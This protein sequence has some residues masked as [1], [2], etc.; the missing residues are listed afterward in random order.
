MS[1]WSKSLYLLIAIAVVIGIADYYNGSLGSWYSQNWAYVTLFIGLCFPVWFGAW[2]FLEVIIP[3]DEK[4]AKEKELRKSIFQKK[5]INERG[6]ELDALTDEEKEY[7][8]QEWVNEEEKAELRRKYLGESTDTQTAYS[9]TK[10]EDR[11]YPLSQREKEAIIN[12]VGTKCCYPNCGET[13]T[14]EVHHII[15]RAEGGMNEDNNLIVLCNNHHHLADR[16]AIPKDRLRLY[17]IAMMTRKNSSDET[18]RYCGTV[19]Y[20][21]EKRCPECGARQK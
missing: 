7:Q 21:N 17:N 20:S 14:L 8:I 11:E 9:K 13:L 2:F 15:P 1:V 5:I 19:Y 18:C 16:G 4:I 12:R 3:V 6:N 10:N